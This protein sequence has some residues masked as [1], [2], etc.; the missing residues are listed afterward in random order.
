MKKLMLVL[1][2]I[3]IIGISS[4]FLF[5]GRQEGFDITIKNQTNKEISGL[6]L[7]YQKITSDIKIPP[8]PS[9]KEYKFNVIP[10][11]NFGEN[12]MVL[13]YKDNEGQLHTEHVFGYFEKGY[14]G[15]AIIM[16][17]A[18]DKNGKLQIEVDEKMFH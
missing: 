2:I 7:T 8:I 16:L 12:S 15:D 1:L 6:S 4:Y 3:L 9:N 17:K 5:S 11:E 13:Y 14:S 10:K 18:I